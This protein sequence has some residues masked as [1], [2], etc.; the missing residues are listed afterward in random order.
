[1]SC[2]SWLLLVGCCTAEQCVDQRSAKVQSRKGHG[3]GA[4]GPVVAS[5]DADHHRHTFCCCQPNCAVVNYM[6]CYVTKWL[7]LVA[8]LSW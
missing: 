2:M 4:A 5:T 1:V 7:V 6:P 3:L 8:H